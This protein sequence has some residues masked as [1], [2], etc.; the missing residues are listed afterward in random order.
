MEMP[1]LMTAMVTPFDRDMKV[2]HARA[3]ELAAHL[4]ST[5]SEGIVVCGT[6]GESPVLSPAE[7]VALFATVKEAVGGSAQVW[8]G[9]GS[10]A[11]AE[12]VELTREATA[13]GV[14]GVMAVVPYYNKPSQQGLYEHYRAVAAA[15][16]L[17]VMMY[18]IPGRTGVNMLPETVQ[19]LA[20]ID[21]I[22]ALKE[23]CGVM[24]QVSQLRV[25]LPA[26]F[27]IYSG[28]DS[29]TLPMMAIGARGVVSIASHIAG[30]RIRSMIEA[31]VRGDTAEAEA[32][33][34]GLFP[35]F[36]GLFI[37]TNP[38]PL[39]AALAM[40]GMDVGGLR[41][42]L[43]EATAAEKER[44]RAMLVQQGYLPQE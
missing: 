1:R 5:G 15:T 28:D 14:D 21:N 20:A 37:T 25:L 43:T 23:A 13:V 8:A 22:V 7:K 29:L 32:L 26:E 27:A 34:R 41:L 19:A 40:L 10:Y 18:N 4:V 36:R 31:F 33:H 30:P 6:T 9:T 42:P 11:T 2:D 12:T 3:R 24:D 35:L 39:K 17:P 38:I 44:I 16:P